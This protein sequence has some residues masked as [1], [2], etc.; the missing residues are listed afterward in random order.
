MVFVSGDKGRRAEQVRRG[1]VRPQVRRD[2]EVRGKAT[3]VRLQQDQRRNVH[4]LA[5][6]SRQ[7]RGVIFNFT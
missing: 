1:C 4:L 5:F 3:G 7:N 6:H 2:R